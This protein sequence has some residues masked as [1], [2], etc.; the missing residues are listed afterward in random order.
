MQPRTAKFLVVVMEKVVL[1]LGAKIGW[2]DHLTLKFKDLKL[3]G[4]GNLGIQ[5][6]LKDCG[7]NQTRECM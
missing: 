6:L 4:R 7:D 2:N 3:T 1:V 5:V